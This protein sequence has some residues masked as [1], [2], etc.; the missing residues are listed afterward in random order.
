MCWRYLKQ[1]LQD[2]PTAGETISYLC[3]GHSLL[4]DTGTRSIQWVCVAPAHISYEGS[5]KAT[6]SGRALKTLVFAVYASCRH[7][8]RLRKTRF[9]RMTVPYGAGFE[10][11]LFHRK[12][13]ITFQR[14]S[15]SRP[16]LLVRLDS[17]LFG[18]MP[19]PGPFKNVLSET[20]TQRVIITNRLCCASKLVNRKI[21]PEGALS[22]I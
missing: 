18:V 16:T 6:I 21:E 3:L 7:H 2:L 13:C 10:T 8:R 5:G 12:V 17:I 19:A 14:W 9:A 11:T 1:S 15:L 22:S 4:P 20:G